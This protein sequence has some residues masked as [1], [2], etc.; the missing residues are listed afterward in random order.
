VRHL[1]ALVVW[2]GLPLG[3]AEH[4]LRPVDPTHISIAERAQLASGARVNSLGCSI[5]KLEPAMGLDLRFRA[6]LTTDVPMKRVAGGGTLR[7]LVVVTPLDAPDAATTFSMETRVPADVASSGIAEM[8][9]VF[10]VGPGR[11]RT[12]ALVVYGPAACSEHWR[13]EA[14]LDKSLEGMPLPIPPEKAESLPEDPFTE[15]SKLSARSA[16][17]LRIKVLVN[18]APAALDGALLTDDDVRGITSILRAVARETRFGQ[19]S[20]VAF[21][22]D[23]QRVLLRQP[24]AP[25]VDFGALKHAV[26]QLPSGTVSVQQLS[27]PRSGAIFLSELLAKELRSEP[28]APDAVLVISPQVYLDNSIPDGALTQEPHVQCPVFLLT[29]TPNARSNPWEG[30][31]GRA[32]KRVYRGG[33]FVVATPRD[34]SR[35]LQRLRSRLQPAR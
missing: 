9:G 29:Y 13:F 27:N 14:R 33:A 5:T 25:K 34:L 30:A 23:Q 26:R 1:L 16:N 3:A 21:S 11:Y 10:A 7:T 18:Y 6:G 12:D 8:T 22:S 19:F 32:I 4:Q 2:A 15:S 24:A 17:P 28:R 31:L 20:V 35:A